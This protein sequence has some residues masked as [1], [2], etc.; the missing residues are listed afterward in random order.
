MDQ[1]LSKKQ[2]KELQRQEKLAERVN[3]VKSRTTQR[4][5]IGVAVV[6]GLALSVWGLIKLGASTNS[7]NNQ[8]NASLSEPVTNNDWSEGT[9]SPK[10]I[11][12]EYSDFQCP[13]CGKFYPIVKKIG[14]DLRDRL[15][16]V[17]RHFPLP[18]HQNA[19]LAA[20]TAEA[21]GAQGKFWEM[22]NMLFERQD[23]WSESKS[24]R[25]IF[26]G[27]ADELKLDKNKFVTTLDAQ[28]TADHIA[29]DQTSGTQS[30]VDAT[31]TFFLNGKKVVQ[32][33]SF[34][35]LRSIIDEALK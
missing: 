32:L 3:Q 6:V 8:T 27:Y 30:G 7:N 2:Q 4:I 13:A 16:I 17:Y 1:Q 28:S 20:K 34:S 5:I 15:K 31:P 25:D 9:T 21:A 18:Q 10:A 24:A 35:D 29:H 19:L 33:Q 11:L 23:K 22:H 12:V 14:E 26:M